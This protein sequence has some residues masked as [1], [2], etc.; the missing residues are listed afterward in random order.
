[1]VALC[2]GRASLL[3]LG[4]FLTLLSPG[5]RFL[6]GAD[7]ENCTFI[8]GFKTIHDLLPAIVGVCADD[9]QHNPANGDALQHTANGLLV[10]RKVDNV[11]AFTDGYRTWLNGPQ[12]LEER[13]NGQRFPW[14][15]NPASLP[16]VADAPVGTAQTVD[17]AF[18]PL[19]RDLPS[20]TRVP[21]WLPA[22]A[23]RAP[24]FGLRCPT[25]YALLTQQPKPPALAHGYLIAMYCWSRPVPPDDPSLYAAGS[26]PTESADLGYLSGSPVMPQLQFVDRQQLPGAVLSVVQLPS[27]LMIQRFTDPNGGE[28]AA[29]ASGAWQYAVIGSVA[30]AN[31]SAPSRQQVDALLVRHA[32]QLATLVQ[33]DPPVTRA[34]RGWVSSSY[35]THDYLTVTWQTVQGFFYQVRWK[36]N[37]A[38]GIAMARTMVPLATP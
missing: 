20:R 30:P 36:D 6:P 29:W 33:A 12:G 9:E 38:A 22:R 18:A 16:V 11:A 7:A 4:I 31:S 37:P 27:G 2:I 19:A 24:A 34:V 26:S 3:V 32:T 21:V 23:P 13:L 14:E 17:A 25:S 1:L 10:W 5:I 35:S 15:S 8:L 28:S